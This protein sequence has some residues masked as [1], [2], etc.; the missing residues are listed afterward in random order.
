M[1]KIEMGIARGMYGLEERGIQ[2]CG[3]ETWGLEPLRIPRRGWEYN[4]KTCL[5]DI[6]AGACSGLISGYGQWLGRVEHVNGLLGP[7]QCGECMG[8]SGNLSFW[9]RSPLYVHRWLTGHLVG[10]LV[11]WLVR[12]VYLLNRL[13]KQLHLG[14]KD[15]VQ[16]QTAPIWR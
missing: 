12:L 16:F 10:W 11:V 2:V 15:W 9:G 4:I 13:V 5:Q 3:W 8:S 6:G 1:K 14:R 7:I